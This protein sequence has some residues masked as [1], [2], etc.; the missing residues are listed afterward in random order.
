MSAQNTEILPN[1][2]TLE[3]SGVIETSLNTSELPLTPAEQ[4]L[5]EAIRF[6]E[7]L[8][9]NWRE[10]FRQAI[11]SELDMCVDP[12]D[13]ELI[14][15]VATLIEWEWFSDTDDPPPEGVALADDHE[16][17]FVSDTFERYH[18]Y[19]RS[20]LLRE[21]LI[22]LMTE[23][24]NYFSEEM[25]NQVNNLLSEVVKETLAYALLRALATETPHA[26]DAPLTLA[27]RMIRESQ[28]EDV[29]RKSHG[30]TREDTLRSHYNAHS[31]LQRRVY[32]LDDERMLAIKQ[33]QGDPMQRLLQYIVNEL[34]IYHGY[35]GDER[36][37]ALTGVKQDELVGMTVDGR[38]KRL[39]D[40][41][42][43]LSD[44]WV[45]EPGGNGVRWLEKYDKSGSLLEALAQGLVERGASEGG[46]LLEILDAATEVCKYH[47]VL[48]QGGIRPGL[49][50]YLRQTDIPLVEERS[51][52]HR[53]WYPNS[54]SKE[55]RL[56]VVSPSDIEE[57]QR[58]NVGYIV[59]SVVR[60]VAGRVITTGRRASINLP[61]HINDYACMLYVNR[62]EGGEWCLYGDLDDHLGGG[63][64]I[65]DLGPFIPGYQAAAYDPDDGVWY[66]KR[67]EVD[68]YRGSAEVE[69][70][71]DNQ[72]ILADRVRS[73]GLLS[74]ADEIAE[75]TDLNLA[76]LTILISD[77]SDYT[78]DEKYKILTNKKSELTDEDFAQLVNESGR[79]QVQC[80][81]SATFLCH[82]LKIALPSSRAATISGH[83]VA[84]DGNIRNVGHVQVMMA[85]EGTQYIVDATPPNR[86]M[87]TASESY[88]SGGGWRANQ[89]S[90]QK[91]PSGEKRNT[92]RQE[93]GEEALQIMGT[94]QSMAQDERA[95][96]AQ[97]VSERAK[98]LLKAHFDILNSSDEALYKQVSLLKKDADPLRRILELVLRHDNGV[99]LQDE[100]QRTKEFLVNLNERGDDAPL[101]RRIGIPRYDQQLIRSLIDIVHDVEIAKEG[102]LQ[103]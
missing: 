73:M 71:K 52:R 47:S 13:Q 96:R 30:L 48:E 57:G 86:A 34:N 39:G 54:A 103:E 26:Y 32:Q 36:I 43:L 21:P 100:L 17:S 22:E 98:Q 16:L 49:T 77:H 59:G 76:Q 51:V 65:K 80:T 74:L 85:H 84:G 27:W 68:P 78:F 102:A 28:E 55:S 44:D 20:Y 60:D 14:T 45:V 58:H 11:Q 6:P 90:G 97:D 94:A 7:E 81:G 99:L 82:M 4:K 53:E 63:Y 31:E 9:R 72:S 5:R 46:D 93:L 88:S 41:I 50:A 24:A 64:S 33:A 69:I 83:T 15:R 10:R 2:P 19:V 56:D 75:A 40:D 38:E 95:Q 79:L 67:A 29:V 92:S 1:D 3:M 8:Q 62:D 37:V 42:F 91:H 61:R 23:R 18:P 89:T 87:G 70:A 66:F 25:R 101:F 35:E 12:D